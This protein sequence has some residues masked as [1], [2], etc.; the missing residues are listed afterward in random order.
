MTAHRAVILRERSEPNG[1]PAVG[2]RSFDYAQD[3]RGI[4]LKQPF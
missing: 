4:T 3:D 1:S 2:M